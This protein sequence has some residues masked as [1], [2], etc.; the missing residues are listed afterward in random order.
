MMLVAPVKTTAYQ[1]LINVDLFVLLVR[2]WVVI[3][4]RMSVSFMVGSYI[5]RNLM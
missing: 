1:A 4:D 2:S 3:S 5:L